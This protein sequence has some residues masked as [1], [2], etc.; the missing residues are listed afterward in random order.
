MIVIPAID[1]LDGRAVRLRPG[2]REDATVSSE[3][4][5]KVEVRPAGPAADGG[6]VRSEDRR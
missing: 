3:R 4:P 1:L 5:W 6:T 2:R